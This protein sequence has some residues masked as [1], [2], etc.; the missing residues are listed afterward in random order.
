MKPNL[1]PF[2]L[3]S[4]LSLY[5][6]GFIPAYIAIIPAYIYILLFLGVVVV[7]VF[8]KLRNML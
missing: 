1:V 3:I 4:L 2:I 5:I 7:G 6:L 8:N